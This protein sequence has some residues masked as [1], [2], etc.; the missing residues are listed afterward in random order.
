[1]DGPATG[2]RAPKEPKLKRSTAYTPTRVETI[3]NHA[4]VGD[5]SMGNI[6]ANSLFFGKEHVNGIEAALKR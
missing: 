1:M 4:A 2:N 5:G 6:H 3:E